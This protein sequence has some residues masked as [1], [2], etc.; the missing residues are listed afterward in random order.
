MLR[1]APNKGRCNLGNHRTILISLANTAFKIEEA[2]PRGRGGKEEGGFWEPRSSPHVTGQEQHR[3]LVS[4]WSA[5]QPDGKVKL[6]LLVQ[7]LRHVWLSTTPCTAPRQASLSF[8]LSQSL[9]KL[10]SIESVMPSNHLILFHCPLLP[11]IFPS[12]HQGLFQWVSSSHQV[13]KVSALSD[14]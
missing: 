4:C 9:L 2:L 7:C 3:G 13:A 5:A 1:G 8:T 14:A 6:L 12:Q 10:M 11:S